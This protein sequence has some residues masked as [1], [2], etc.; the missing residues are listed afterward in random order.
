METQPASIERL[1]L[2]ARKV[3][4]LYVDFG[5][6]C[7]GLGIWMWMGYGVGRGPAVAG[8]MQTKIVIF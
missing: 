5:S 8:C 4:S 2:M 3:V 1:L 6:A 7:L